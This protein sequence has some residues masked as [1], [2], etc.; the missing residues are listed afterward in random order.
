MGNPDQIVVIL[1]FKIVE[2]VSLV[3]RMPQLRMV[4]MPGLQELE[5]RCGDALRAF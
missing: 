4:W 3:L 2:S 5:E 1:H